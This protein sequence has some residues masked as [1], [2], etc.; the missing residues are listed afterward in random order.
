VSGTTWHVSG[1]DQPTQWTTDA[2]AYF[3]DQAKEASKMTDLQAIAD[4]QGFVA[5]FAKNNGLIWFVDPDPDLVAKRQVL[6]GTGTVSPRGVTAY[7]DA[8]VFYPARSGIRSMRARD[9]SNNATTSDIG[10]PIDSLVRAKLA[11]MTD[12]EKA[13]VIGLINPVDDRLWMIFPDGEIFVF[14]YFPNAKVS[15]WTTY[16]TGFDVTHAVVFGERVYLRSGDTIYVYG[17]LDEAAEITYDDS[18]AK[19][20]LPFFDGGA[21]TANKQWTGVDA[22]LTGTWS[23]YGAMQPTDTT[24]RELLMTL[25]ETTYNR[26]RHPIMVDST[27]LGLQFET[28]GVGPHVLSAVIAHNDVAEDV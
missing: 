8:D 2:G 1:A 5:L 17:G 13:G 9:S 25:S 21:P 23:V 15:A 19:A 4:Y 20:H 14:S 24:I 3:F 18:I 22:S 11:T 6:A 27:H 26:P 28:S 10:S 12:T 7:G 16:E